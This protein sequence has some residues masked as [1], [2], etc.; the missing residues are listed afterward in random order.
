MT[1]TLTLLSE[2]CI[3][4]FPDMSGIGS[5]QKATWLAPVEERRR[6]GVNYGW[7]CAS[8]SHIVGIRLHPDRKYQRCPGMAAY[9]IFFF[10]HQLRTSV[11]GVGGSVRER[12]GCNVPTPADGRGPRE[13]ATRCCKDPCTQH[14]C[15]MAWSNRRSSESW[16]YM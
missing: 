12:R 14:E 4:S 13:V 5:L 6:E 11:A 7:H 3:G 15:I 2:V 9:P 16:L 1:L 8:P 10:Q